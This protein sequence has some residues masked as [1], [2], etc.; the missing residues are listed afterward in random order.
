[1]IR[2]DFCAAECP[3]VEGFYRRQ[4]CLNSEAYSAWWSSFAGNWRSVS[5][6]LTWSK[7]MLLH[8]VFLVAVAL[9]AGGMYIPDQAHA[10]NFNTDRAPHSSPA[11]AEDILARNQEF[12]DAWA[13]GDAAAVASLYTVDAQFLP[14]NF[15]TLV[16]R[17]AIQGYMQGGIDQ[18]VDS[19]TLETEELKILGAFA[20]EV[21][22]YT[23]NVGDIVVDAGRYIV[24]WKRVRGE[25]Y[26]HRDITN[27]DQTPE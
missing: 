15:P 26:L 1:M 24:I 19:I 6:K 23:L 5:I 17:D 2:G 21:G 27:T 20:W 10:F 7:N 8:R 12:M 4:S 18:G 11:Q 16:G 13:R 22:R 9:F 14:A 25:W 3:E